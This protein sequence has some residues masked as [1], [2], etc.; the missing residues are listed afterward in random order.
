MP[1]G[2]AVAPFKAPLDESRVML[3]WHEYT[4]RFGNRF[5]DGETYALRYPEVTMEP[6]AVYAYNQG[7]LTE[8][9]MGDYEVRLESTIGIYGTGLLDAISDEARRAYVDRSQPSPHSA[10][11]RHIIFLKQLLAAL[12]RSKQSAALHTFCRLLE[13]RL[14]ITS[15]RRHILS[16]IMWLLWIPVLT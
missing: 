10:V 2:H 7:V 14:K 11:V 15:C 4:D 8:S 1:Q 9:Q 13:A 16:A 5:D 6:S 3:K 12:E